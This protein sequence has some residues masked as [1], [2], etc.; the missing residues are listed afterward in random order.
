MVVIEDHGLELHNPT[1]RPFRVIS[2][3]A[4]ME[5]SLVSSDFPESCSSSKWF[6]VKMSAIGSKCVE[7]ASGMSGGT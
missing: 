3:R 5:A 1:V 2:R 6:G 4:E 7:I